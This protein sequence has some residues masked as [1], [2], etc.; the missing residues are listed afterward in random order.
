MIMRKETLVFLTSLAIIFIIGYVNMT[1]VPE[2]PFDLKEIGKIEEANKP[3]D[4]DNDLAKIIEG[5]MAELKK[6]DLTKILEQTDKS[7]ISVDTP[8][9]VPPLAED[10]K[11]Y[12]ILGDITDILNKD[13]VEAT[14]DGILNTLNISFANFKLNRDKSNMDVIDHLEGTISN[15]SISAETKSQFEGL[16]LHKSEYVQTE[17]NIEMMLQSKGYNETIVIVDENAV[18]VVTNDTIEQADAT[19]IKD[20]IVSETNYEPSQIKI[21][22]FDNIDL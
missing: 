11:D 19:K 3:V 22:K 7:D 10:E 20:V 14:S 13:S 12:V 8:V 4:L 15:E 16:L 17:S 1:M 6:N 21:V 18:K 9:S 5:D 2:N